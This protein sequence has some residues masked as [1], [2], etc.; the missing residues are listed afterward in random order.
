MLMA[1]VFAVIS[2][3]CMKWPITSQNA[4]RS[5]PYR[6]FGT[7]H[8]GGDGTGS[9][10]CSGTLVGWWRATLASKACFRATTG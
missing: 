3:C 8:Y 10:G 1:R 2:F 7:L 9:H 5:Y 4:M 6:T